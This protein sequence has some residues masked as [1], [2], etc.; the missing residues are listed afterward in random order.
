[1]KEIKNPMEKTNEK[2]S[3]KEIVISNFDSTILDRKR[4]NVNDLP[5]VDLLECDSSFTNSYNAFTKSNKAMLW[6]VRMGHA[7]LGYLKKLQKIWKDNRVTID[8]I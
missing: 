4:T 6:H 7:S 3:T 5:S 2:Q 8:K 1:V